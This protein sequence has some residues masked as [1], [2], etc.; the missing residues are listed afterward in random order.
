MTKYVATG[1]WGQIEI[2]DA[3]GVYVLSDV[4]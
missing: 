1:F 2:K 3:Y 4:S